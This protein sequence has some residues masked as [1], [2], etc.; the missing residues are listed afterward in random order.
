MIFHGASS[1]KSS[2]T[3]SLVRLF[4]SL[5]PLIYIRIIPDLFKK[6]CLAVCYSGLCERILQ[7]RLHAAFSAVCRRLADEQRDLWASSLDAAFQQILRQSAGRGE[8]GGWRWTTRGWIDVDG[9]DLAAMFSFL[10]TNDQQHTTSLAF[11]S[12]WVYR[13]TF[14]KL[15]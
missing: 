3:G 14:L 15:I 9:V 2:C 6:M 13:I 10:E 1:S 8:A 11:P 4:N 12:V 5:K 7:W